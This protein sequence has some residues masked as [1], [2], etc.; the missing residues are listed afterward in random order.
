MPAL[1]SL[2][3]LLLATFGDGF[4]EVGTVTC[5]RAPPSAR[6]GDVRK[7]GGARQAHGAADG[8][9]GG[10]AGAADRGGARHPCGPRLP[11]SARRSQA[12]APGGGHRVPLIHGP[13]GEAHHAGASLFDA[14]GVSSLCRRFVCSVHVVSELSML[15][16]ISSQTPDTSHQMNCRG[17]DSLMTD[18]ASM[19]LSKFGEC[20]AAPFARLRTEATAAPH[21]HPLSPCSSPT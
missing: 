20:L 16:A 8:R 3:G 5:R 9:G 10:A 21:T 13:H 2:R 12:R 11:I 15:R 4:R 6:A 18:C 19:H 7:G 17:L 14:H 1:A